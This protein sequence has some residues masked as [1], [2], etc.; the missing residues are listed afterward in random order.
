MNKIITEWSKY[1]EEKLEGNLKPNVTKQNCSLLPVMLILKSFPSQI[2]VSP[3]THMLRPKAWRSF[4][5]DSCLF[6]FSLTPMCIL[7]ASHVNST[8]KILP[9]FDHFSSSSEPPYKKIPV[10]Q[11]G[12]QWLPNW[13]PCLSNH[14][15]STYSPHS[16]Q[17]EISEM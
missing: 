9:S 17:S 11:C 6:S 4:W 16:S 14:L 5:V 12:F 8:S 7:S 15:S 10:P 2:M 13:P 3:F 1:S